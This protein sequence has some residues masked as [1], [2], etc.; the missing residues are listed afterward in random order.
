MD[1]NRGELYNMQGKPPLKTILFV[2]DDPNLL[3]LLENVQGQT[4]TPSFE[5]LTATDPTEAEKSL[6]KERMSQMALI[7]LYFQRKENDGFEPIG[8][9]HAHADSIPLFVIIDSQD[10]YVGLHAIEQGAEDFLFKSDLNRHTLA[11]TFRYAEKINS[12]QQ[13][14]KRQESELVFS[15]ARFEAMIDQNMDGILLLDRDGIVTFVNPA[16]EKLFG[17]K[18]NRMLGHHM[19]FPILPNQATEIE[20][21][22]NET[23]K[24]TMEFRSAE[25]YLV[26]AD[27]P[28]QMVVVRDISEKKKALDM[29]QQT[30]E[31]LERQVRE[32]TA[33]L[34]QTNRRLQEEINDRK[35]MELELIHAKKMETIGKLA[36]GMAHHINN[37]LMVVT[38]GLE[39]LKDEHTISHN[40]RK[41]FALMAESSNSIKGMID[42]L[43]AYARD[44]R[45]QTESLE[46]KE[47]VYDVVG[48]IKSQPDINIQFDIAMCDGISTTFR[49]DPI[50]IKM[51]IT[52]FIEN[53]IESMPTG[54]KL[55]I[56]VGNFQMDKAFT[57]KH[58]GS[59]PGEYVC[60][61]VR[62]HGCGVT[63]AIKK[64]AF[65]PFFSTKFPGRGMGLAAA[66][67]IIKNHDGYIT[68]DTA[69]TGGSIAAIYL[70]L[71]G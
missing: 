5:I 58:R 70:P 53:A 56:K 12:L 22:A 55:H 27:D 65:E 3:G 11:R 44:G 32:R 31:D 15:K 37:K 21:V 48:I 60:L 10:E 29:L 26:S 54:G 9:L 36:G 34:T 30:R 52:S 17:R 2:G 8:E 57:D 49:G 38:S 25:I 64:R 61:R 51:V 18:I 45:Y 20:I 13:R 24:T 66:Y 1:I 4:G 47:L 28:M 14:L 33:I 43:L 46:M 59:L 69:E 50:Q 41:T 6:P 67:G 42:Q 40:A 19:E 7:F 68:L 23:D 16:A 39:L 35:K 71:E 63:P 62:D